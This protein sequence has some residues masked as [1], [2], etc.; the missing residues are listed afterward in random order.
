MTPGS[1]MLGMILPRGNMLDCTF[2][3]CDISISMYKYRPSLIAN[4]I[5]TAVFGLSAVVYA[6]QGFQSEK[7]VAFTIAMV[8]GCLSE[9]IGYVGRVL[10]WKDPWDDVS[11]P[12]LVTS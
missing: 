6:A 10:M 12:C 8:L 5:F 2:E 1:A 3:T 11:S 7:F 9:A 4:A